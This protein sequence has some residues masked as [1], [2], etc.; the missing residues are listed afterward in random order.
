MAILVFQLWAVCWQKTNVPFARQL[1]FY[2]EAQL[3]YMRYFISS[4][5]QFWMYIGAIKFR[6]IFMSKVNYFLE[7]FK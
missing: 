7:I 1:S 4:Y 2:T 3:I 6:F 5:F